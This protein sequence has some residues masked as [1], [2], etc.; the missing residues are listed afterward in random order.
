MKRFFSRSR[1]RRFLRLCLFIF[2]LRFF[3]TLD[4]WS[5]S[6]AP[7]SG[8]GGLGGS[9]SA[10]AGRESESE[11]GDNAR[12][13]TAATSKN[14]ERSDANTI[15]LPISSCSCAG[16]AA[17]RATLRT[18]GKDRLSGALPSAARSAPVRIARDPRAASP[19]SRVRS[20]IDMRREGR[21]RPVPPCVSGAFSFFLFCSPLRQSP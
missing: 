9:I 4:S 17:A 2:V 16:E 5:P 6:S 15:A 12:A 13:C 10:G 3:F 1:F 19:A 21:G 11:S 20:S 7:A 14:H 18:E 8:T